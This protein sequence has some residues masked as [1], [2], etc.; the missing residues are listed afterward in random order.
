MPVQELLADA[1]SGVAG[2]C[3]FRSC[4]LMLFLV[5]GR[6]LSRSWGPRPV[7]ELLVDVSSRVVAC[8]EDGGQGLFSS[9]WPMPILVS[10]HNRV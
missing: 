7:Q 8:L 6:I 10:T 3:L 9:C 5:C 4:W 1:C 2:R